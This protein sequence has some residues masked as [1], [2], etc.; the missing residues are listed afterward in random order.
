VG[1]LGI[2]TDAILV[3][4]NFVNLPGGRLQ[5][6]ITSLPPSPLLRLLAGTLRIFACRLPASEPP[7]QGPIVVTGDATLDGT[8]VLQFLNGF[9]PR[10]GDSF[11]L[12]EVAGAVTGGFANVLVRG[13][14][15]GAEPAQ[16]LAAGK[17]SL[18]FPEA[19]VALPTVSL[20]AKPTL[21]ETKKKGAKVKF[22][23]AGDTSQ[24]LLVS[25][26]VGGSASNGLDYV[27]LPAAL[28]I[29]AGKKSATLLVKPFPDGIEEESETIELELLP[30][31][32]YAP[33]L[34]SKV[35]IEVVDKTK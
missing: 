10:A 24:P 29:P 32:D 14:A 5:V 31:D 22:T 11:D 26:A 9:A 16:D 2:K 6:A 7:P 35:T 27:E 8:L 34:F 20:K 15:P 17:L 1:K 23:R 4:G 33:S 13:L 3:D 12:I 28:E 25:Y 21:K 18:T 19:R 30:G